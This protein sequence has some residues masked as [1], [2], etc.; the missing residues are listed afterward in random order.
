MYACANLLKC[1]SKHAGVKEISSSTV[2]R[3]NVDFLIL[4]IHYLVQGNTVFLS[5]IICVV[6]FSYDTKTNVVQSKV[7]PA[8]QQAPTQNTC[9]QYKKTSQ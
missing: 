4:L 1:S 7:A 9:I 8:A 5:Y 2:L 3:G 6:Y